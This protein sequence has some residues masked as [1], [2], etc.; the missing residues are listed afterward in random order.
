MKKEYLDLYNCNNVFTGKKIL[1][2]KNVRNEV[3]D[4]YYYLIAVIIIEN[5][6]GEI[7]MQYTSKEKGSIFALTGG[8][9]ISGDDSIT[10]IVKEVK[11]EIGLDINHKDI[12]IF[13][14]F[15][16]THQ[17]W[18]VF[19][20]KMDVDIKK[21]IYQKSE[22]EYAEFINKEKLKNMLKEKKIRI[23]NRSII[24]DYLLKK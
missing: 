12:S 1:R 22:V 16:E 2:T 17:I 23:S 5:T 6:K 11:E 13:Q 3:E 19:Y 14:T 18:D 24:L 9:V 7:L 10:C 4:G 21:L 20:L 8:H 15:K